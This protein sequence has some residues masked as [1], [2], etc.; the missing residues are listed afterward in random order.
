MMNFVFHSEELCS[1][2]E[3]ELCIETRNCVAKMMNL[4]DRWLWLRVC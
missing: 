2:N 1:K 4:A 3:E